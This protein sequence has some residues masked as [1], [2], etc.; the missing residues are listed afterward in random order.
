MLS[1]FALQKVLFFSGIISWTLDHKKI[2]FKNH[3]RFLSF[4]T[5]STPLAKTKPAWLGSLIGLGIMVLPL[6][7]NGEFDGSDPNEVEKGAKKD[8]M[9]H[10]VNGL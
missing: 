10:L 8:N 4:P 2:R 1:L 3:F 7:A 6:E 5:V 9:G